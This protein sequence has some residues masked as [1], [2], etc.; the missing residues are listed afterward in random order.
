MSALADWMALV[1]CTHNARDARRSTERRRAAGRAETASFIFTWRAPRVSCC[2]SGK[3][4]ANPY[5]GVRTLYRDGPSIPFSSI[6]AQRI[7]VPLGFLSRGYYLIPRQAEHSRRR[8]WQ[9][10]TMA[11]TIMTATMVGDARVI[12][13]MT[14]TTRM[15]ATTATKASQRAA[16]SP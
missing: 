9:P 4:N 16:R 14:V 13:A 8:Q 7:R 11:M 5:G 2:V 3:R 6:N 15:K 1:K 10:V 12:K